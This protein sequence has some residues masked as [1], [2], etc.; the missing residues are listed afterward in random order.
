MATLVNNQNNDQKQGQQNTPGQVAQPT[1][2]SGPAFAGQQSGASNTPAS[3]G[4]FVNTQQFLNANKNAGQ[5]IGGAIQSGINSQLNQEKTAVGKE[6]ENVRSG[7]QAA[8]GNV[9]QGGQIYGQIGG[10][11]SKYNVNQPVQ[12][13]DTEGMVALSLIHI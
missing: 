10:D 7:I 1:A 12:K 5:Q 6:A 4:R 13:L 3:S 9:Q 2:P 8:Q 11:A